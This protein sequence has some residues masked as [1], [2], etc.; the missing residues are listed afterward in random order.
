MLFI[1]SK[2]RLV[3]INMNQ[4]ASILFL[5]VLFELV[6]QYCQPFN[7]DLEVILFVINSS[8]YITKYY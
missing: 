4:E 7:D 2:W 1:H 8:F 6:V 5:E 3:T